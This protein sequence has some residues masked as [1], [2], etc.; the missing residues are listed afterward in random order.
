MKRYIHYYNNQRIHLGLNK[1]SPEPR[2]VQANEEF[3]RVAV[4][5][6]LHHFYLRK[7]A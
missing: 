7:A 1:D 2:K 6:G 4:A 5:N 3:D